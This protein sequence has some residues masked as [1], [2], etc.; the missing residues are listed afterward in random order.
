MVRESS[1]K[2]Q[3]F[4]IVVLK[5]EMPEN[6]S[7]RQVLIREQI[8]HGATVSN[9][10]LG[11]ST[12]EQHERQGEDSSSFSCPGMY[13]PDMWSLFSAHLSESK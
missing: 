1:P 3:C 6:P 4:D 12:S 13:G 2:Q 9:R 5:T 10:F 8:A 7:G 11:F